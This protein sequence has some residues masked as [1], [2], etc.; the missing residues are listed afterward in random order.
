LG[1]VSF[2]G[3]IYLHIAFVADC[4][5]IA[6]VADCLDIAVVADCLH[7]AYIAMKF[8]GLALA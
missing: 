2:N 3:V 1:F 7:I 4:L 8:V 6:F 5:N